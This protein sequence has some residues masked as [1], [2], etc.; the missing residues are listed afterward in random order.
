[1]VFWSTDRSDNDFFNTLIPFDIVPEETCVKYAGRLAFRFSISSRLQ[2]QQ[3]KVW[4]TV[5]S[6]LFGDKM[7][8]DAASRV[9]NG[10][11]RA[12][13]RLR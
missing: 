5:L 3:R 4:V 8:L 10:R 1:V 7:S 13:D 9:V 11:G 2:E 6:V 12:R